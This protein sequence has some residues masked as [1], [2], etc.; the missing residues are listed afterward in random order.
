MP[1]QQDSP[2]PATVAVSGTSKKMLQLLRERI[3][4]LLRVT[5]VLALCLVLGAS[6]FAIWWLNSLSGLPDIGD[7]FDVAAFRAIRVPDDENALILLKRAIDKLETPPDFGVPTIAWSQTDPTMRAWLEANR[8]A[9]ELFQRAAE[10]A[11]GVSLSAGEPGAILDPTRL[12]RL[13]LLEGGKREDAGDMAGSWTCSRAILRMA[14]HIRRRG[15]TFE[16]L[17]VNLR[18]GWLR[19][20]LATWAADQRTTIPQ[21][22]TALAEALASQPGPEWDAYSLKL[23][24]LEMLRSLEEPPDHILQQGMEEVLNYRLADMQVPLNLAP[25]VY[26]ARRFLA[27]EPER[28]RRVLRLLFA[29]YLAHVEV[30]TLRNRKPT[31]LASLDPSK[32]K[33]SVPIYFVSPEAPAGAHALPPHDV[34]RWLATTRD[35]KFLLDNWDW[36]SVRL[37]ERKAHRN[38][39]I[40]LAEELYH[41]ERGNL[42]PSEEAL[43]GT[44]LTN[45]PD[46]SLAD[47]ADEMAPK[48]E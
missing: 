24:Y 12:M 26:A 18:F 33:K 36:Q 4:Q 40:T 39:V 7:P 31:L 22:R 46:N 8:P 21:I 35:A 2:A 45:L 16:R 34:A 23:E 14:T 30:P 27:R 25:D 19:Q 37:D 43:V 17:L 32:R 41:R 3:R 42:P 11:E 1:T 10:Q 29:N 44:Y 28:S 48:V 13:A 20:R 47:Q 9:L 6:A 15:S 38:L 5:F